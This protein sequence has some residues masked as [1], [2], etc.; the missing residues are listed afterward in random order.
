VTESAASSSRSP[1]TRN[2]QDPTAGKA[3]EIAISVLV[4]DDSESFLDAS[5][6]LLRREGLAVTGLATTSAE[7]V[8]RVEDLRPDVVLVDVHLGAESGSTSLAGWP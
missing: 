6:A 7:A 3:G 4:V 5:S 1:V 2:A 8:A